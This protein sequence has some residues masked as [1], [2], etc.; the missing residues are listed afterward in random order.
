MLRRIYRRSRR[1]RKTRY[2]QA[3]FSNRKRE[4]GW[5]PPSICSRVDN[6]F[7][8]ID[9][10]CSFVSTPNLIIEVGKFVHIK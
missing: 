9:R 1:N 10:F 5:L 2:R 6:T 3:R 4:E 8:W 7:F